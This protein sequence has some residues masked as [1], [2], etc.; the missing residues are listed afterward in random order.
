M[1]RSSRTILL[2]GACA[3]LAAA[4]LASD[5]G[6]E[7]L[8]D[9]IALAYQTNPTLL[10][11]RAA[12]RVLDESYVQARS[13]W[14][15]TLSLQGQAY[16]QNTYGGTGEVLAQTGTGSSTGTGAGSG[17]GSTGQTMQQTGAGGSSSQNYG[18]GAIVAT[19]P[20]YTGG[21]VAAEVGAA[22]AAVHAGRQTLRATENNV[23]Q[24]VVTAYEDV[25]RDQQILRIR[26]DSVTI[27]AGQASETA[28]KFN[29]G[30]VTRVDVAQAQA[31][32]AQ[33]QSLLSGAR[34]GLQISRAEY[35]AAVGQ[36]PGELAD[37]PPLPGIPATVDQA[38]DA[39]NAQSPSL[40]QAQ[41]SEQASR[42]RIASA[43]ANFRP[44]VL[45]PG[46][47]WRGGRTGA[48]RGARLRGRGD[49]RDRLLPA[50]L[51]RRPE[52]LAGAPGPG[53]EQRRPHLH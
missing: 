48:V 37:P 44:T 14:N 39:A 17:V 26:S 21:K 30:Q 50:D 4:A 1:S 29:V 6:A 53:P 46:Q 11:Q 22:D 40:L 43:R 33:A 3:A 19:Q 2:A 15:P 28:A 32:L 27:L 5:A 31:Q 20:L 52:R 25:Q 10:A 35:V 51:H 34:A 47:L 7:T 42:A 9:A 13:G 41:L 23:L 16:Y 8:A 49:R 12:Q 45:G 24:S 36:S 18:Y 38:F